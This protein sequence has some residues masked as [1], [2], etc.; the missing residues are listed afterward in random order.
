MGL[1]EIF[2]ATGIV[3]ALAG[4]SWKMV[5]DQD[6]K[7]D[8]VFRRFDQYKKHLEETHV[9]DKI[10]KITHERTDEILADLRADVKEIL[11]E[12]RNGKQS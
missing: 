8:T 4:F 3:I 6:K 7:I 12:L 1:T 9:S 11:R 10:C 2:V 5:Y